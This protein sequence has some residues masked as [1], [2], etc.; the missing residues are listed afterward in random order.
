[1]TLSFIHP[2][3][4]IGLA[5][6]G[7]PVLIHFLTRARP[8]VIRYPTYH[9]LIE[10]GSGRQALNRLRTWIILSLRVLAVAALALLF[11]K[12]FLRTAGARAEPGSARRAV[13]LVDASMSMR[14]VQSGVPVFARA[15][16][17]A[18]DLLRSLEQGSSAG[19]V[20]IGAKPQ[21][22]L[23]ALSR[24]LAVLHEGLAKAEATLERGD[25]AAA[26]ALAERMLEGHGAVYVFSDFQRSN[27]ASV[28]LTR[29]QGLSFFLRP[30]VAQGVD[31]V[32]ITSLE[33]SPGEPIEGETIELTCTVFNSTA[34][35]RKE[36][37]R[38]DLEGVTQTTAVE[39][40]PY[41]SGT[42]GF[43]FSLPTSG[44]F[45]GKVALERDDLNDDNTRYFKLR[46]R[47][48]LDVL[49]ISDADRDDTT[50][51]AFF[52]ATALAP[53]EYASGGM[54]V[55]RRLS[56]E[57]DRGALETADAFF[58]VPPTRLNGETTDII[59]RRVSDGA[60]LVCFL[61]GATAPE[62]I[63]ALTG[64]SKGVIAPPYQLLRPLSTEQLGGE[65]F[66][67]AQTTGGPLKLFNTPD[68]GDLKG[69]RFLRR[70]VTETVASRKE[71]VLIQFTDGSAALSMSPAGR[72]TAVF[73]NF[74]TA[75]D[76]SNLA[77]SP[78]F[79]P[80]L[81]EL[82]RALRRVSDTDVNTPG[83][84]CT[85]DVPGA[86]PSAGPDKPYTVLDP[87]AKPLQATVLT[88]GRTVRLALPAVHL[89]GLYPVRSDR[90]L[91]DFG[92]VNV[93]PDETDTRQMN[94]TDLV[95]EHG[96]QN[97]S[98]TLLNSEG[99]IL[100]AGRPRALWPLLIAIAALFFAAEMMLLAVWRHVPQRAA[101][102]VLTGR[103]QA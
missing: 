82:M 49:V 76:G 80:L 37:V 15:R 26:I 4:L 81:H 13:V 63:G 94:V 23:P 65:P 50:S 69:L 2:W 62:T 90:T 20:F 53:S 25:P 60:H 75:P 10:A 32:G 28:D 70:Y 79:P 1:V 12:P 42:A 24:N 8:R 87:E 59:A 71:E 84:E 51:G 11:T 102:K 67:T 22:V 57:V 14:A 64:A 68:Q 101:R 66:G 103:S 52:V 83:R 44:C 40:Q 3:F 92:V 95:D 61:D 86:E 77:G 91:V 47:R 88:R 30:V 19:V 16:A 97:V 100:N 72:G 58:L 78:L 46:V 34:A 27:W 31:N 98:V 6:V 45:P 36:T 5:A 56:Q 35:K 29:Y 74:S 48:A 41:S 43:S 17:Q 39:L 89:S 73:A 18:A 33:K 54:R 99:D 85:I 55:L 93:H 7:L 38:L 96:S 9:L 21:A